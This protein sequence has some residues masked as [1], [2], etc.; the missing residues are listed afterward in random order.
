MILF[1][2]AIFCSFCLALASC[3]NEKMITTDNSNSTDFVC[4]G[5]FDAPERTKIL[6]GVSMFE[7][8]FII[9][10]GDTSIV[11]ELICLDSLKFTR[12]LLKEI[13]VNDICL[14]MGIQGST[15]FSARTNKYGGFEDVKV[16]RSLESCFRDFEKRVIS[17]V[18][19]MRI[20]QE[21]Y[22]NSEIVFRHQYR[23][24]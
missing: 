22:F 19:Q 12:T 23:I 7:L 1:K 18:S 16:I 14:E 13:E 20:L 9:T 17:K 21:E 11:S 5:N 10:N 15:Y 2:I 24:R 3:A 4:G 6:R 8:G